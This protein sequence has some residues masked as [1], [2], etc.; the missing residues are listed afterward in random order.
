MSETSE[1]ITRLLRAWGEGESSAGEQLFPLVYEHLRQIA[2][3]QFAGENSGHTLRPTALVHEAFLKL[4]AHGVDIN[5]R[6][7][8][9]ALAARTMRNILVDHARGRRREKRGGDRVRVTLQDASVSMAAPE[10]D[11]LDLDA[12]LAAL[13]QENERVARTIEY[14]YFGGLSRDEVSE[15][16][17]V[18]PRTVD[19]DLRLGRA[20]LRTQLA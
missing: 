4:D 1:R 15:Q 14:I 5:D 6:R 17:E 10:A 9:Y 12:A 8:F 20:W 18:S 11:L 16:L 7:H 13:E 19:R 3:R 2:A